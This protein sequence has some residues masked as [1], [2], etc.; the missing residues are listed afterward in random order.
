[1]LA[2]VSR[3]VFAYA[4]LLRC[5]VEITRLLLHDQ[6]KLTPQCV[7]FSCT[8]GSSTATPSTSKAKRQALRDTDKECTLSLSHNEYTHAYRQKQQRANEKQWTSEPQ[9]KTAMDALSQQV[10]AGVLS[11]RNKCFI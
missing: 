11:D 8:A 2:C 9:V 7:A 10:G 1:M 4:Q 6:L 3:V 5:I